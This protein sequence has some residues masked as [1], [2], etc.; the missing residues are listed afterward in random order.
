M[1]QPLSNS[2]NTTAAT[3]QQ[4]LQLLSQNLQ[5]AQEDQVDI[6]ILPEGFLQ[7]YSPASFSFA[8]A[9]G[10]PSSKAVSQMASQYSV[11]IAFPYFELG[12]DGLIYDTVDVYDMTGEMVLHYRK[13]NLAA[14]EDQFLTPGT[15]IGPVVN[16]KTDNGTFAIGALICF[17]VFYPEA[18]RLLALQ[19]AQFIIIPTAN[20]YP[21]NYNPIANV[22]VPARGLE[23]GVAVAYVN[24]VQVGAGIPDYLTF[25][26]TS[27]LVNQDVVMIKGDGFAQQVLVADLNFNGWTPS[28]VVANRPAPDLVGLCN[29]TAPSPSPSPSPSSGSAHGGAPLPG[30]APV[31]Q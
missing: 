26:G 1:I 10:G 29:G 23:N 27:I 5:Q 22:L 8:E 24:W 20:G 9:M 14:G 31:R 12:S 17:D 6:V 3:V 28:P 30:L 16:L 7:G 15:T 18:A 19:G 2:V 25:H 11:A 4:H 21:T 13:V